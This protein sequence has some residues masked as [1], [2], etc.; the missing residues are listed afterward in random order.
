MSYHPYQESL[1][2]PALSPD[3]ILPLPLPLLRK[4]PRIA[5]GWV[6]DPR[7]PCSLVEDDTENLGTDEREP[8][9]WIPE[10]TG[11]S[12]WN[13][14][15]RGREEMREFTESDGNRLGKAGIKRT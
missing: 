6:T 8:R 10:E 5:E 15:T 4:E 7:S 11:E 9:Y 12:G 2:A 14:D 13:T 1:P 3:L